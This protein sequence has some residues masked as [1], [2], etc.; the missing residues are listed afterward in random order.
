M[1]KSTKF[2][3]LEVFLSW[4]PG[5]LGV[6]LV[7]PSLLERPLIRLDDLFD[8]STEVSIYIVFLTGDIFWTM[9]SLLFE[10]DSVLLSRAEGLE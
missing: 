7:F 1:F 9:G 8:L 3:L 6:G 10:A 5:V 2:F 4:K